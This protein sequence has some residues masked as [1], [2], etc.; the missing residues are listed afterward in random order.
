MSLQHSRQEI[1]L[2]NFWYDFDNT[3]AYAKPADVSTAIDIINPYGRLISKYIEYRHESNYLEGLKTEF[4][5]EDDVKAFRILAEHQIRLLQDHFQGD[6]AAEIIAFT[7]FAQGILFDDLPRPP[8]SK[9]PKGDESIHMM[10]SDIAS[11]VVWH[12]FIRVLMLIDVT[13]NKERWLEIDKYVILAAAIL[14]KLKYLG[15]QPIRAHVPNVNK[16]LNDSSLKELE[17]YWLHQNIDFEQ[18]DNAMTQFARI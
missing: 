1:A 4:Q 17:N 12:A 7:S 6:K 10:N 14:E 15:R 8:D 9:R 11:Y 16:P 13:A 3:F 5:N 18:I 2:L